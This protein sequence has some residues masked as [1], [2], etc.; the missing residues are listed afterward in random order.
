MD[1]TGKPLA[2]LIAKTR[3]IS[4]WAVDC[5]M[6]LLV[7]RSRL[8]LSLLCMWPWHQIQQGMF[9]N[10]RG[11]P[12]ALWSRAFY[13]WLNP[14]SRSLMW[15]VPGLQVFVTT[16]ERLASPLSFGIILFSHSSKPFILLGF[17]S[18]LQRR[19]PAAFWNH[20]CYSSLQWLSRLGFSPGP[21]ITSLKS[22]QV[23]SSAASRSSSATKFSPSRW[24]AT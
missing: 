7:C 2:L 15:L 21:P 9:K 3:K 22:L 4:F 24:W 13:S 20:S 1:W 10:F 6:S 19:K 5:P 23:D 14:F 18:F 16:W 12:R 17:P 11:I 8:P